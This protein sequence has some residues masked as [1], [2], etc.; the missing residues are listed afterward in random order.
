MCLARLG[1]LP[2]PPQPGLSI[3]LVPRAG[4]GASLGSHQLPGKD[5]GEKQKPSV[6]FSKGSMRVGGLF[7]FSE[8]TN[9]CKTSSLLFTNPSGVSSAG[10]AGG[11]HLPEQPASLPGRAG[12]L[13]IPIRVMHC[14]PPGLAGPITSTAVSAAGRFL[15]SL[16]VR[17][18][19]L[20]RFFC[21]FPLPSCCVTSGSFCR[22]LSK[23]WSTA[24]LFLI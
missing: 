12:I 11:I 16:L 8:G 14:I 4:A 17:V 3:L 6:T 7:P 5:L 20:R 15:C 18:C 21:E 13:S 23:R 24:Q 22:S 2:Q 10:G 9:S 19:L 1:G